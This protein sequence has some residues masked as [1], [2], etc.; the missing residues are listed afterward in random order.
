MYLNFA[1]NKFMKD[2]Q[3][4][5]NFEYLIFPDINKYY[6]YDPE[7]AFER[8]L[9]KRLVYLKYEDRED[10]FIC[11]MWNRGVIETLA[12]QPR[13][14][15]AILKNSNLGSGDLYSVKNVKCQLNFCFVSNDPDYLTSF[16]EF[17][18]LNYDR[19]ISMKADYKIPVSERELGNII[20]IDNTNKSFRFSGHVD[21]LKVGDKIRVVN[22]SSNN[23][24]YTVN[25]ITIDGEDTDVSVNEDI[26]S[27]V[28]D[29]VLAKVNSEQVLP[30]SIYFSDIQAS[31]LNKLVTDSRGEL[32][33]LLV[34]AIV[35]YPVIQ[36][37]T[38]VGEGSGKIIKHIHLRTKSVVDPR[39]S[40]MILP[41]EE[42]I[43]E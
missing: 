30:V 15:E 43:I 6:F 41:Y 20:S 14:L 9:Q 24:D 1:V 21:F 22:S 12:E 25:N 32:T 26:V 31:Q 38:G 33:F 11:A 16:E 42:T 5:I 28:I 36:N 19:S 2:I 40:S 34:S 7:L 37:I 13:K 18:V 8:R 39:N 23:G 3:D 10:A 4:N 29:G 17:F 27:S 35:Q